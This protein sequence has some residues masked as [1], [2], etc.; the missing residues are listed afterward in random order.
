MKKKSDTK[1]FYNT[2]KL[3]GSVVNIYKYDDYIC[4]FSKYPLYKHPIGQYTI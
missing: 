3:L 1:E 4:N 2:D